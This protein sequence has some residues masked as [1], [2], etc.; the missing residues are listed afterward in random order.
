MA[1][2]AVSLRLRTTKTRSVRSPNL[3]HFFSTSS[4]PN[5]DNQNATALPPPPPP[6]PQ[7]SFSSYFNDVKA[8]VKQQRPPPHN[9]QP[10]HPNSAPSS[11]P[12]FADKPAA[13][14]ASFEEIRKNIEKYRRGSATP[15][16][17]SSSSSFPPSQPVSF[18][19][20]YKRNVISRGEEQ[21]QQSQQSSDSAKLRFDRIRDSL[22]RMRSDNQ[23]E[24]AVNRPTETLS[25]QRSQDSLRIWPAERIGRTELQAALRGSGERRSQAESAAAR[26]EFVRSYSYDELGAKL[27]KLR[28]EA[29]KGGKKERF[30]LAEL[31]ERLIKLR[32][33]EEQ[34]N[35]SSTAGKLFRDI[36]NRL[37]QTRL[38]E[39]EEME[40]RSDIFSCSSRVDGL[41][42]CHPSH[43]LSLSSV[44]VNLS[45]VGPP[46]HLTHMYMNSSICRLQR[47]SMW[48][49]LQKDPN[50][51]SPMATTAVSLH[52]RTTKTRSVRNPN[53]LHFFS[54]STP[55][56]DD[57]N[58]TASPP[59]P[60]FSS[61]FSDVKASL[62][63][64]PPPPHHRQ[65]RPPNN[66]PSFSS[67]FSG[68]P[69]SKAASLEEIH[70]NLNEFRRRSTA[71]P[72]PPSSPLSPSRR[73]VSFQELYK[74]K[75]IP[76]GEEQREQNQQSSDSAKLSFDRIRDSLH[77]MRSNK[78]PEG[79]GN[80]PTG[81]LSLQRFQDSGRL[82]PVDRIG[83]TELP[84]AALGSGE[85][86]SQAEKA[87]AATRREFLRSYGYSELGAKLRKLRPEAS[88]GGKK[89]WF[90]LAELNERLIMLREMEE[91]EQEQEQENESRTVSGVFTDLRNSLVRINASHEEEKK[92]RSVQRIDVLSHLGE[93]PNFM[94]GPPKEILVEKAKSSHN[95]YIQ[96]FHPDNM[97]SSEKLKLELEKVRDE[98]KM[99]VSDCGSSRVQV[100]QLTTKIKHLSSTLHKKDKHSR[101]GLQAMIERRKKLL[102]Y[103]RETDWDSYCLVL[104]KLGLRD[105]NPNEKKYMQSGRKKKDS[106]GVKRYKKLKKSKGGRQKI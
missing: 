31:N 100:A 45:F 4:T 69:D 48:H 104:S 78:Q 51:V 65:P 56:P 22:N 64:Q 77:R 61:Y 105:R 90:S 21:Q 3:L 26:M 94:L 95:C 46:A 7:S 81:T 14:A 20:L 88:K 11:S 91:Q 71:P 2:T 15:Q 30:S 99:S 62:K 12:L 19:E 57:Q 86:S 23:P 80:R 43:P 44:I 16:P 97:S 75:V 49:A 6:Q 9:R 102:T 68:K 63:Q 58:A 98:F 32:E 103:L 1:T 41:T 96:Y 36:R 34:E 70:K 52:L 39:R 29:S 106:V 40:K 53:L 101:K 73:P 84:L 93:T 35:E 28:P 92:K 59:P 8:S 67:L 85:R 47:P 10:S 66:P 82:R 5:P 42:E 24:G 27:R 60:P 54:S 37:V 83:G 18:Q 79:A 33:M 55:N 50:K 89:E 76:R 25:L 17:P 87:E 74:R 13:K 38:S 72:P